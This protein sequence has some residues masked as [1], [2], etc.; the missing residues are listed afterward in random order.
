MSKLALPNL[1]PSQIK[2]RDLNDQFRQT[3]HGGRIL[4]T[5]G[6]RAL[7]PTAVPDIIRLI[8][9]FKDFTEDNDPYGEHD[10]GAFRYRG[11]KLFWKIDYYSPDLRS[12]S[13]NPADPA[14]TVRVLTVM[15]ATEY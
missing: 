12:G 9:D 10:F 14:A 15:L 7:G 11:A 1:T 6:S 13:P 4:F 2:I 8:K 5:S 3:G